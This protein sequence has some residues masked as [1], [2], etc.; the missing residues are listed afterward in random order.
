MGSSDV[1][2]PIS[3][4]TPPSYTD[5]IRGPKQTELLGLEDQLNHLHLLDL[6]HYR[7][8]CSET[9]LA[10]GYVSRS[11]TRLNPEWLEPPK[12]CH[13]YNMGYCKN[14]IK[15]RFFHGQSTP[16][17]FSNIHNPNLDEF[18]NED[19]AITPDSLAKLEFEIIELLKSKRGT[20]VSI[21]SLPTLSFRRKKYPDVSQ[22]FASYASNAG[23]MGSKQSYSHVSIIHQF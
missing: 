15:C 8:N 11:H 6:D 3:R 22:L 12:A 18:G 21:A 7:N 23:H 13:Y 14:G 16:D 9:A 17:G 1:T 4:I 19:Q 2:S 10:G 20:P 5:L